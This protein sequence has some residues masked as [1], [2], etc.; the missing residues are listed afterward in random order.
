[1]RWLGA[2]IQNGFAQ[3]VR[4]HLLQQCGVSVSRYKRALN[5]M[6]R[7]HLLQQRGV[8]VS[9]YKRALNFMRRYHLLQQRGVSTSRYRRSESGSVATN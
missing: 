1:V 3:K 9:R 2:A 4:Y 6:R 7:Y 8:S 5:F